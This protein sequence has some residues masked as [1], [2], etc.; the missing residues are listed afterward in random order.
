MSRNQAL[1]CHSVSFHKGDLAQVWCFVPCG[2]CPDD[3][4]SVVFHKGVYKIFRFPG[5]HP[6]SCCQGIS[7]W[8]AI[9]DSPRVCIQTVD[10]DC[11]YYLGLV[12]SRRVGG[13]E[14]QSCFQGLFPCLGG[15]RFPVSSVRGLPLVTPL[16]FCFFP[17]HTLCVGKCVHPELIQNRP[18][19][20][21]HF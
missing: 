5:G 10:S 2:H 9:A 11:C 3:S 15:N 20:Q 18:H 17:S 1:P 13:D 14:L 12:S 7:A 16:H 21:N 6:P 4:W 19:F 8:Q